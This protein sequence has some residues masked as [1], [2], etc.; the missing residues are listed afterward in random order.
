MKVCTSVRLVSW[1]FETVLSEF[2]NSSDTVKGGLIGTLYCMLNPNF[3]V[4][5]FSIQ[6]KLK[7]EGEPPH[8]ASI[9]TGIDTGISHR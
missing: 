5:H 3:V 1:F 6:F 8:Y 9:D 4:F 7:K 2:S